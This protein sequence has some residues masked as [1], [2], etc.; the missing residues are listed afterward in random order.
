MTKK[1][2]DTQSLRNTAKYITIDYIIHSEIMAR[3]LSSAASKINKVNII[4]IVVDISDNSMIIDDGT[5]TITV[6]TSEIRTK[7]QGISVGDP[8]CVIGF[9]S[10]YE[11][12]MII[13]AD[14]ITK[15]NSTKWLDLRKLELMNLKRPIE[16]DLTALDKSENQEETQKEPKITKTKYKEPKTNDINPKTSEKNGDY[17]VEKVVFE[18]KEDNKKSSEEKKPDDENKPKPEII[19]E[20]IK[21]LDSGDGADIDEV[22][23]KSEIDDTEKIIDNLL[24]D[25]EIYEIRPGRI[26]LL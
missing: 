6:M 26:K 25:G 16:N 21:N 12:K 2:E 22:V 14:I 17:K 18:E 10:N 15:L 8:V 13:I 1:M 5:G 20:I 19:R 3:D 23:S 11:T 24:R 4:A 9:C 7:M